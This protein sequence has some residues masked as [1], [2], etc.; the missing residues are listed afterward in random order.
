MVKLTPQPV[1]RLY[2]VPADA[3]DTGLIDEDQ[4]DEE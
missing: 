2:S 1:I 4:M 3:F